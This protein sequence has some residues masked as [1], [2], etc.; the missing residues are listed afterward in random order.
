MAPVTSAS[1]G[2]R[3]GSAGPAGPAGTMAGSSAASGCGPPAAS[4]SAAA[5]PPWAAAIS[6]ASSATVGASRRVRRGRSTPSLGAQPRRQAGGEQG[7]P[8]QVVEVVARA[9]PF[10]PEHPAPDL[11]QPLLQLPAGRG[12]GPRPPRRGGR[13]RGG[14][15]HPV[16]PA[17]ERVGG[18]RDA[19]APLPRA[20][21]LP[22]HRHP[23]A[24]EA[25]Q[26]AQDEGEVRDGLAGVAQGGRG[27]RLPVRPALLP[28]HRG[29]RPP[30][31]HLQEQPRPVLQQRR[32]RRRRSAPSRAGGGPSTPGSVAC[33]AR[34]PGAGDVGDDRGAA[35]REQRIP[36]HSARKASQDRVHHRASGRRARSCRR[37]GTPSRRPAGAPAAPRRPASGRRRRRRRGR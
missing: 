4:G 28:H 29:Q 19:A 34:D 3:T 1:R 9:D 11:Q 18:E 30:R 22:V 33:A 23:R 12:R 35:G 8:A 32:G 6:R 26:G 17:L 37:A 20:E 13:V 25:A 36:R 15:A 24:P 7:V 27:P 10:D 31:T 2:G 21:A 16:P 14:P 5:P